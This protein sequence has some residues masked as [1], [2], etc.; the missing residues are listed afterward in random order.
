[1]MEMKRDSSSVEGD[2]GVS[3]SISSDGGGVGRS[4]SISNHIYLAVTDGPQPAFFT[5]VTY[6]DDDDDDDDD[7]D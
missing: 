5:S 4:S 1:M 3:N 2:E 7:D 6:H